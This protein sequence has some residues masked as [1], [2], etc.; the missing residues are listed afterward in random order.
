[1]GYYVEIYEADWAIPLDNEVP[2]LAA[3]TTVARSEVMMSDPL[4][5]NRAMMGI[6]ECDTLSKMLYYFGFTAYQPD[7]TKPIYINSYDGRSTNEQD[8]LRLIARYSE[9]GSWINWK[10]EDMSLWRNEVTPDRS[11]MTYNGFIEW[12]PS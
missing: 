2:L 12:V 7:P 11:L 8:I 9:P 3:L 4:D 1:M 5:Q 6:D 10:G